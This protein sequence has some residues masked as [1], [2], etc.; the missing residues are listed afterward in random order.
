MNN[1][2]NTNFLKSL[3][4]QVI[5]LQIFLFVFWFKNGFI[6]KVC[7]VLLGI[8]TPETAYHGD[9]WQGWKEYIVGTWDKSA[10]GHTFISPTFDFMFPILIVLQ[11]V[12]FILILRSVF[13]GE[14]M[15][16]KQR[17][18]LLRAGIASL[19]VTACMAFTQT[20][21]G[22]SDGQY[23]WQFIGFSMVAIMYIRNENGK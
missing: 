8:I 4:F 1:T 20:I 17:P 16:E 19:F 9:T 3:A 13:A 15:Q 21:T 11:C 14:F 23:L 18:W 22:A 2:N 5:P 12:P 10:V 6:D 7:G